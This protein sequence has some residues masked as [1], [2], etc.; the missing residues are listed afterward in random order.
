VGQGTLAL[1]Q[2]RKDIFKAVAA[3][4]DDDDGTFH[5]TSF[6]EWLLSGLVETTVAAGSPLHQPAPRFLVKLEQKLIS[7]LAQ[8]G[9]HCQFANFQFSLKDS[10]SAF[11]I[12][13][14]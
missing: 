8:G 11:S 2:G 1:D 14:P 7:L 12:L 10:S 13:T 6:P 9:I 3:A 4:A 5:G